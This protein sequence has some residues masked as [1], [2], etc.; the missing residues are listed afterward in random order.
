MRENSLCRLLHHSFLN[1]R[2]LSRDLLAHRQSEGSPMFQK[3]TAYARPVKQQATTIK[4]AQMQ[5]R[6]RCLRSHLRQDGKNRQSHHSQRSDH[7]LI[8]L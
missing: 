6:A 7:R 4:L 8:Q 5:N 3:S 1:R 2:P